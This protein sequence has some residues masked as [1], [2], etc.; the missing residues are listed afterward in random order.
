MKARGAA[1]KLRLGRE[2][3]RST[4]T[5]RGEYPLCPWGWRRVHQGSAGSLLGVEAREA[6]IKDLRL[7]AIIA[8]AW[9][10]EI[11]MGSQ[12]PGGMSRHQVIGTGVS[13]GP[14][15]PQPG[16]IPSRAS[17]GSGMPGGRTAWNPVPTV[18]AR[19]HWT[20]KG[21]REPRGHRFIEAE[22]AGH[23]RHTPHKPTGGV[24]GAVALRLPQPCGPEIG[25]PTLTHPPCHQHD[26]EAHSVVTAIPVTPRMGLG[27]SCS[28][29][30]RTGEPGGHE[31]RDGMG[32]GGTVGPCLCLAEFP[33][34]HVE[35][36]R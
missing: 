27:P 3:S 14:G 11:H 17:T 2:V 1:G 25:P 34:S 30:H 8:R 29:Q 22:P 5:S 13:C 20:G 24:W 6:A 28:G 21:S 23:R 4:D 35:V 26:P 32:Q 15:L 16:Y 9:D 19:G 10:C 7:Q 33:T 36:G 12:G 18:F 31:P